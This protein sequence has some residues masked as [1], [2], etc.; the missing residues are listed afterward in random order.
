MYL[1]P[2]LFTLLFST[3]PVPAASAP[4][5]I[6][7]VSTDNGQHW[8][9]FAEGLPEKLQ[10]R[11]V[12]DHQGD[13][14]LASNTK[15]IYVLTA[16]GCTWENRSKGLPLGSKDFFPTALSAHGKI[17]LL[18]T[19]QH[20]VYI[21]KDGG[22]YWRRAMFNINSTVSDFIFNDDL[23]LAAS[24]SGLWQS[25]D[26][27]DSWKRHS[28]DLTPINALSLHNDRLFVARQNGI[29]I[30][31]DKGISWSDVQPEWAFAQ[32]LT[33]GDYL[34]VISAKDEMYRTK[35]GSHWEPRLTWFPNGLPNDN[36]PEALWSGY[37]A[38]IPGDT[39][40]GRIHPTSRGWLVWPGYGC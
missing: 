29:G 10:V 34:Y 8:N 4:P 11:N 37:K 22:A 21:S 14:F 16:D 33:G 24:H 19:Y 6:L 17:I 27:G 25:Y 26:N 35:D 30:L 2:L 13:L 3:A 5:P 39:P 9:N 31:T 15:G 1:F 20:G 23:L 36:L 12:M 18:G 40:A 7:Y 28:T 32:L 38:Q